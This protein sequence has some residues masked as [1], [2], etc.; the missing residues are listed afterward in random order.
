MTPTERRLPLLHEVVDLD[1]TKRSID[2]LSRREVLQILGD[3][4][5]QHDGHV[6]HIVHIRDRVPVTVLSAVAEC[7]WTTVVAR[8]LAE[9]YGAEENT[10]YVPVNPH[11]LLYGRLIHEKYLTFLEEELN[12]PVEVELEAEAQINGRS[13]KIVGRVDALMPGSG[14]IVVLEVKTGSKISLRHMVQ[15]WTY[16]HMLNMYVEDKIAKPLFLTPR[17]FEKVDKYY[18]WRDILQLISLVLYIIDK[19]GDVTWDRKRNC[20]RTRCP[21][22]PWCPK[23]VKLDLA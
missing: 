18:A 3:D 10:L 13:V 23:A 20:P 2:R 17:G 7:P 12:I 9:R 6:F 5:V 15:V 22:Y 4:F 21:Y 8:L 1:E 14:R 16:V 19:D 11:A